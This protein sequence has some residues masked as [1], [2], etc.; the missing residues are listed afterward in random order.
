M[1]IEGLENLF[2]DP[3]PAES[4]SVRIDGDAVII[5]FEGKTIGHGIVK[6]DGSIQAVL[7]EEGA[8]LIPSAP[9]SVSFADDSVE[10]H[11]L[12]SLFLRDP[13]A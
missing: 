9:M 2:N 1:G 3:K 13:L 12:A 8:K 4:A 11:K 7:N 6:E 10:Q 5:T